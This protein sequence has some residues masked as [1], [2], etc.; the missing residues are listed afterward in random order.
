MKLNDL[1]KMSV[2]VALE[3]E[4]RKQLR[5]SLLK[6]MKKT[7]APKERGTIVK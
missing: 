7:P 4:E 2:R 6:F 5:D 3:Q 1:Q